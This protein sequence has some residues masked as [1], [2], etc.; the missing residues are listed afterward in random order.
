MR[1]S[2]YTDSDRAKSL[3]DRFLAIGSREHKGWEE[4]FFSPLRDLQNGL[5][6]PASAGV[7]Q[8]P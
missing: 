2:V 8:A 3:D 7:P 4:F 5:V 6:P 1:H